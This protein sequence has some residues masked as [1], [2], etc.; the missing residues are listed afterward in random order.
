MKWFK[1]WG[2]EDLSEFFGDVMKYVIIEDRL[3]KA[4]KMKWQDAKMSKLE[5]Y[6]ANMDPLILTGIEIQNFQR[7]PRCEFLLL[8]VSFLTKKTK[9]VSFTYSTPNPCNFTPQTMISELKFPS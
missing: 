6:I 8:V 3:I 1:R 5:Y 9:N 2:V 7:D 4:L